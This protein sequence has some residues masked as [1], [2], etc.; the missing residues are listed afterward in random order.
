M[1]YFV[2]KQTYGSF[3]I[4]RDMVVPTEHSTDQKDYQGLPQAIGAMSKSFADG[5]VIAPHTHE[6][7][8]LLYAI[9]GIMRLRTIREA[10]MVSPDGAVYIPAGTRHSITMHGNVEMRTLYIDASA[11]LA[12]PKALCVVKVSGLLRELILALS[13]ETVAYGPRSRAGLLAQLIE[14]E[15]GEARELSLHIPL[16]RDSRL[17]RLCAELLADPSSRK[18]LDDWSEVTGASTRTL[19]RLFEGDLGIGFRHWRQRV[20]FHN[21]LEALSNGKPIAWVAEH[22]G[23][24][25]ASAFSAAFKKTMGMS[26]SAITPRSKI[27]RQ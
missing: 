8:Q 7:D 18:T 20:R 10:W 15:L 19:A 11:D 12:R 1:P 24:R 6:R 2:D 27:H 26:P 14:L 5:F 3:E 13:R 4:S 23:Y 17:Q 16:P 21:A 9:S 25:S 22:H